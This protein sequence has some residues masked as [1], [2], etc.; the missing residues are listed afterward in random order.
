[1]S[2]NTRASTWWEPGPVGGRG[3]L[4][5]DVPRR[6]LAAAQRF[7]E[8]VALAPALEHLELE[9]GEGLLRVN[10]AGHAAILGCAPPEPAR[11]DRAGPRILARGTGPL[12]GSRETIH[13]SQRFVQ[14]EPE[15]HRI[16]GS[17]RAE[18]AGGYYLVSRKAGK[19]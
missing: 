8:D 16:P 2:L 17:S 11:P 14:M 4:V 10:G 18:G 7:G 13:A 15:N 5:E 6:A 1:M 19:K 12:R 9:L 3:P